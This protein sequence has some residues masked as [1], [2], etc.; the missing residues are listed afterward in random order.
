ME[1]LR[2]SHDYKMLL[3]FLLLQLKEKENDNR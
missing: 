3:K 2:S 1:Q